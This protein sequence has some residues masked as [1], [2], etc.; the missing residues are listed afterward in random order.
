M[1]TLVSDFFNTA[2]SPNKSIK[3]FRRTSF[4]FLYGFCPNQSHSPRHLAPHAFLAGRVEVKFDHQRLNIGPNDAF[5]ALDFDQHDIRA[6]GSVFAPPPLI[7][8]ATRDQRGGNFIDFL[9]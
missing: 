3:H 8:S 7:C 5:V 2:S 4:H 1:L 9:L 6:R